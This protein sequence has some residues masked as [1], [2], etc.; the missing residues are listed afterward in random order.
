MPPRLLSVAQS[1]WSHSLRMASSHR[2]ILLASLICL[3]P[4]KKC[5]FHPKETQLIQ[6]ALF[7]EVVLSVSLLVPIH[8][9]KIHAREP[10]KITLFV[11]RLL[12]QSHLLL[13]LCK[14]GRFMASVSS[15]QFLII[16]L[17]HMTPRQQFLDP[18]FLPHAHRVLCPGCTLGTSREPHQY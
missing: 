9:P 13:S 15:P 18:V 14:T 16:R 8:V 5:F 7:G 11:T 17:L 2:G 6:P 1:V 3:P 12:C 4:K 10:I